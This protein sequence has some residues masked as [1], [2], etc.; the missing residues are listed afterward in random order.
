M[1]TTRESQ[2]QPQRL[3]SDSLIDFRFPVFLIFPEGL[4][5]FSRDPA[6]FVSFSQVFPSQQ[7]KESLF[8]LLAVFSSSETHKM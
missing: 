3:I 6:F 5:G 7:T 2:L 8:L 4:T 1:V